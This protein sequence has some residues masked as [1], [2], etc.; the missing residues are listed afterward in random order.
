MD[1]V[2]EPKAGPRSAATILVVEDAP[3]MRE[4]CAV[5]LAAAGY[6]VL[7]SA[8]VQEALTVLRGE[9]KIDVLVADYNLGD[10]TGSELI[11]QAS[12]E[13]LFDAHAPAIICTAYRY[14]ELPPRA[15]IVHKP[16]EPEDF[17]RHVDKAVREVEAWQGRR[18]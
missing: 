6:R 11:H 9:Q 15:V 16:I 18:P 4:F 7:T 10:G 3:D 5:A 14:V 12:N 13:G 2:D 17:V 8:S 1:P